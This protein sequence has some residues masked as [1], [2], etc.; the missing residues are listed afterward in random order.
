M[1]NGYSTSSGAGQTQTNKQN[2]GMITANT[3]IP[4]G[5]HKGKKLGECPTKSLE[6]MVEKLWNSDL[7]EYAFMAKKLLKTRESDIKDGLQCENLEEAADRFLREAGVDPSEF[8]DKP[9][10]R[11]I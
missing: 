6:W 3:R 10:R 11:R 4:F 5:M 2:S 1:D 8:K 9:I 7:H